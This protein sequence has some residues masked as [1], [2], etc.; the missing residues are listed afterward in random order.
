MLRIIPKKPIFPA[1]L[2]IKKTPLEG[3]IN[4]LL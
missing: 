3:K 1:I 4:D 2:I